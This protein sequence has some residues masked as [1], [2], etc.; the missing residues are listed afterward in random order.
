MV[1]VT[2]PA[3]IPA[4]LFFIHQTL[5]LFYNTAW[6]V[7]PGTSKVCETLK[8]AQKPPLWLSFSDLGE[9]G[10]YFFDKM[11]AGFPSADKCTDN[12]QLLKELVWTRDLRDLLEWRQRIVQRWFTEFPGRQIPAPLFLKFASNSSEA[13]LWT[14][15]GVHWKLSD[16]EEAALAT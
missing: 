13:V 3:F 12:Q 15:A 10:S 2:H 11:F 16:W 6:I 14:R 7:L 5:Y 8:P 9:I 1:V 4:C